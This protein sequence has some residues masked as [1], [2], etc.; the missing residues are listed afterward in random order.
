MSKYLSHLYIA[1]H[2]A[3]TTILC[4]LLAG[5]VLGW[6]GAIA[7]GTTVPALPVTLVLLGA[8]NLVPI[9]CLMP[10]L[11]AAILLTFIPSARRLM[12]LE[13]SHRS[14]QTGM[15]DVRQAFYIAFTADRSGMFR[16]NEQFDAV[17]ERI[18]FLKQHPALENKEPEILALAA[19]MSFEARELA[20]RYSME[21]VTRA[22]SIIAER[23]VEVEAV[24]AAIT[25]IE[26]TNAAA[27]QTL[28]RLA[29]IKE[30]AAG[31]LAADMQEL[32]T[33]LGPYGFVRQPVLETNVVAMV[34]VA[35]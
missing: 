28:E 9:L 22:N 32:E 25:D 11:F 5:S 27:K 14:F 31:K 35:S 12:K 13:L 33:L 29:A 19:Q 30:T 10:G 34:P 16:L 7:G 4:A 15:E 17:S 3:A 6:A 8:V 26:R 20:A 23:L 2:Y 21:N 18:R 1:G 24:E